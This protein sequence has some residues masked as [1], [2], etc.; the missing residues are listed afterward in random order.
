MPLTR[1]FRHAEASTIGDGKAMANQANGIEARRG[2]RWTLLFWGLAAGLLLLPFVAMRFSASGVDWTLADFVFMG[3]LLGI[4]GLALELAARRGNGAYNL[5]TGLALAACFFLIVSTGAV[6]IIGDEGEAAN[7]LFG[8]V[9]LVAL[10]GAVAARFR[11]PGM[12]RAMAA[13][14]LVQLLVP[15]AALILWP[16][17]AAAIRSPEVPIATLV[18]AAIWLGSAWL[19]RKAAAAAAL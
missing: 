17:A 3:V 9:I 6:G 8:A 10:L 14:A 2:G 1:C 15:V 19:Y 7:L 18:F 12:A 13:A 5:A 16:G 11:A 4:V